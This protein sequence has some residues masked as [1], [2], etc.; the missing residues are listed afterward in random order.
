MLSMKD[1]MKCS[2][3]SHPTTR[4]LWMDAKYDVDQERFKR[5][6]GYRLVTEH[7]N[8]ARVCC[9][10]RRKVTTIFYVEFEFEVT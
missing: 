2:E 7:V 6:A 4:G 3:Q 10:Y 5:F 8:V 9:K 1:E